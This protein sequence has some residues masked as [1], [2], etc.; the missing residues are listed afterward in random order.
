MAVVWFILELIMLFFY[1]DLPKVHTSNS[2]NVFDGSVNCDSIDTKYSDTEAAIST[3]INT[4]G[5]G[6]KRKLENFNAARF[7]KRSRT[8]SVMENWHLAKGWLGGLLSVNNMF[9]LTFYLCLSQ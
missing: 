7:R 8:P 6:E 3:S 4:A 9:V 2:E 5:D 1:F